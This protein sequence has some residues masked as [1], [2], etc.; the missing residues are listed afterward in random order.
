M[1]GSDSNSTLVGS[2]SFDDEYPQWPESPDHAGGA[3]GGLRD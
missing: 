1:K 2:S 3:Q